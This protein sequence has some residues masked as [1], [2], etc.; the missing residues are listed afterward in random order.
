MCKHHK[1]H[2]Y[3]KHL[4]YSE[5]STH[6]EEMAIEKIKK[7][8][9]KK[10]TNVSLIVIRI[11]Y[12]S[13]PDFYNLTNS[14]PCVACISKINNIRRIGYKISKIYFSNEN[15]DIVCYKLRDIIKEKQHLS[16]YY[17][18][19]TIP[20]NLLLEFDIVVKQHPIPNDT[21]IK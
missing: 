16:K 8:R 12:G 1:Q 10:L 9:K 11:S 17:R 5:K 13:T 21:K 4:S 7:N 14:R 6:A 15:G 20:K 3:K 18:T 2:K 19:A